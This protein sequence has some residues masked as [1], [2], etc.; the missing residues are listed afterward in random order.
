MIFNMVGGGSGGL[1]AT[2]AVLIVS[3]PTGSTVTATK[4]GVTLIPTIWVQNVDSTLDTAIFSVKASTFDSN[5]WTVTA[6]LGDDTSSE[7]VVIDSAK[8]Y[9]VEIT[10]NHWIF[11]SGTGEVIASSTG[12][13]Q[14]ASITVGTDSIVCSYTNTDYAQ[15][16]Y[17]TT[18]KIN[19]SLYSSL[20]VVAKVTNYRFDANYYPIAFVASSTPVAAEM[21][22]DAKYIAKATLDLTGATVDTSL[23]L[24][25][26]NS[27]SYV[28]FRGTF[29]GTVTGVYLKE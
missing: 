18:S 23:D 14:N 16:V 27:T 25:S 5:A 20:H 2:D 1:K 19:L 10:Y 8:E 21:N 9:S 24:T 28:G 12:A 17:W 13:Q 22:N 26:I 7:T 29:K 6:T 3:V 11:K 4:N 15:L